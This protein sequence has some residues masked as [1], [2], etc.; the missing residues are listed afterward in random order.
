MC[1]LWQRPAFPPRHQPCEKGQGTL[2]GCCVDL[3]SQP[4]YGPD[5]LYAWAVSR[6]TYGPRGQDREAGKKGEKGGSRRPHNHYCS[7]SSKQEART[8]AGKY[9]TDPFIETGAERKHCECMLVPKQ[10]I[11]QGGPHFV[12][13]GS[14]FFHELS[15]WSHVPAGSSSSQS[16]RKIILFPQ[17]LASAPG[18]L[19][20]EGP[21]RGGE[22]HRIQEKAG[23]GPNPR[24]ADLWPTAIYLTQTQS[25]HL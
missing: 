19:R 22:K 11:C 2:R 18:T 3:A 24:P 15:F 6:V 9:L 5:L 14:W 12:L 8:A 25:P 7:S 17:P 13:P 10:T 20:G 16:F 1:S 4:G 23:P 21:G